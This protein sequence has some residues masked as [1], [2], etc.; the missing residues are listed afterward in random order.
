M[1]GS[2]SCSTQTSGKTLHSINRDQII[3][4]YFS[5]EQTSYDRIESGYDSQSIG[6]SAYP[7]SYVDPIDRARSANEQST[8]ERLGRF[9]NHEFNQPAIMP[10]YPL[11][12]PTETFAQR[13]RRRLNTD[14]YSSSSSSDDQDE[15]KCKMKPAKK[16]NKK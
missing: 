15:Q 2:R 14:M 1:G 9:Q 13:A 11:G 10:Q 12:E 3:N 5:C 16:K 8:P 4:N 6:W 7:S